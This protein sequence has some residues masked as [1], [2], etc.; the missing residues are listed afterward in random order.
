M[1]RPD[2]KDQESDQLSSQSLNTSEGTLH[3]VIDEVTDKD[4]IS[5]KLI[6]EK[7]KTNIAREI[8]ASP[9]KFLE[10]AITE[11][12]ALAE[13]Y[14]LL[15]LV[16]ARLQFHKEVKSSLVALGE[17][18]ANIYLK[19]KNEEESNTQ[20]AKL[21]RV[22]EKYGKKYSNNAFW[23]F[24]KKQYEKLSEEEKKDIKQEQFVKWVSQN[25]KIANW[26]LLKI[27]GVKLKDDTT[28]GK[29]SEIE[30]KI[31]E[32][33]QHLSQAAGEDSEVS[34]LLRIEYKE[35]DVEESSRQVAEMRFQ[36]FKE[37]R[38]IIWASVGKKSIQGED[39]QEK[40]VSDFKYSGKTT[41]KTVYIPYHDIQRV[42]CNSCNLI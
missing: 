25:E 3:D 19:R 39:E 32:A 35:G 36:N 24:F 29:R 21:L 9:R 40:V 31:S 27:E 26:M 28:I 12:Q 37:T 1:S 14:K 15:T 41:A 8:L 18:F 38:R 10:R 13:S 22:W 34:L 20:D 2:K 6:I 17:S 23:N 33:K 4:D 11:N 5:T 42:I 30:A 16:E 7:A